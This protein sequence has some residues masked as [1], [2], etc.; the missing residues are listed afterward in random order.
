MILSTVID[1][2]REAIRSA[3]LFN[4]EMAFIS[5]HQAS[6]TSESS[7]PKTE[8]IGRTFFAG[9]NWDSGCDTKYYNGLYNELMRYPTR[10]LLEIIDDWPPDMDSLQERWRKIRLG[11]TSVLS[12]A[13]RF[14]MKLPF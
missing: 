13:E 7:D 2:F 14:V 4:Q 8:G 1:A 10:P 6:Y 9:G 3:R 11:E 5:K 12:K